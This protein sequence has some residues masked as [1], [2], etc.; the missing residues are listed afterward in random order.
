MTA[1]SP[2]ERQI[3]REL[4]ARRRQVEEHLEHERFDVR[5]QR[6]EWPSEKVGDLF[7]IEI[8]R[9]DGKTPVLA[10]IGYT[11]RNILR[12]YE[13]A[14]LLGP[15]DT[16][17]GLLLNCELVAY[18]CRKQFFVSSAGWRKL[19]RTVEKQPPASTPFTPIGPA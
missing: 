9:V 7:G 18:G 16:A 11:Q 1:T 10:L 2:R 13:S 8:F 5:V 6:G 3:A 19:K 14:R 17:Q 15:L 12:F 4:D